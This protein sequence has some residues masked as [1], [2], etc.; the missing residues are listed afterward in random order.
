MNKILIYNN[1]LFIIPLTRGL[2]VYVKHTPTLE[3]NGK[4][5]NR[6]AET[7]FF[8]IFS[9]SL[10]LFRKTLRSRRPA[11][12][13]RRDD[14][15]ARAFRGRPR[16]VFGRFFHELASAAPRTTCRYAVVGWR[17][18]NSREV[19][20]T[21][22]EIPITT[23]ARRHADAKKNENNSTTTSSHA[24]G[25]SV[26]PSVASSGR[27]RFPSPVDVFF[28][29]YGPLRLVPWRRSHFVGPPQMSSNKMHTN[30]FRYFV[31][32]ENPGS[33]GNNGNT[34]N[35][36]IFQIKLMLSLRAGFIF[37]RELNDFIWC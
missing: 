20:E 26:G 10:S 15:S 6:R 19:F 36:Y 37:P 23:C 33:G 28:G 17:R 25:K 9:L 3:K 30:I 18:A 29:D 1:T 2:Y 32:L 13:G 4:S 16:D 11:R 24:G 12:R 27:A 22:T 21:T 8:P 35:E 7:V 34:I 31:S 5:A 14:V